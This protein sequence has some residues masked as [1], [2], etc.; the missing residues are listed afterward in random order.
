MRSYKAKDKIDNEG[1]AIFFYGPPSYSKTHSVLTLPGKTRLINCEAKDPRTVIGESENITVYDDFVDF[2]EMIVT[3]N[4]FVNEVREGKKE[5]DN[6]F[7]DGASFL[8][9]K[10]KTDLEDAHYDKLKDKNDK[11]PGLF[12]RLTMGED[13]RR[14]WGAL[15]SAM[16]RVTNISSTLTKYNINVIMS[17]WEMENPKYSGIGGEALDFGPWFQGQEFAN[18][19]S[20]FFD[21]IGRIIVP[22][23]FKK[24]K[25]DDAIISFVQINPD[26]IGDGERNYGKYLCRATG[27]LIPKGKKV[28]LRWD[29]II[30][31]LNKEENK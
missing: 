14:G 18:M 30:G 20:G 22:P 19:I 8:M 1:K 26:E 15:G 25:V 23:V 29:K 31:F 28:P 4:S 16:R 7:F 3:L 13:G 21:L 10:Y 5:F 17:A 12:D 24:D 27:K 9:G 11:E 2:D 6:L